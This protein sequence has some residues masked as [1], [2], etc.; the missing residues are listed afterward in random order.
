MTK[1]H[2]KNRMNQLKEKL[3][4]LKD[5]FESLV[6][7]LEETSGDIEP[8]ENRN[9]LTEA[10]EERQEWFDNASDELDDI[11]YALDEANCTI[12]AITED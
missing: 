10:Q 12:D 1:T 8:Y 2:A 5:E 3:L 9:D 7:D 11:V 4:D 6:S